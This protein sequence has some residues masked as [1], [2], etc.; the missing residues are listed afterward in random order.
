MPLKR[1]TFSGLA[2]PTL[3]RRFWAKVIRGPAEDDCWSWAGTKSTAGYGQIRAGRAGTPM[4]TAS[5]VSYEIHFGPIPDGEYVC[6]KCDNPE[7]CNP[8]HLFA[9]T[10]SGNMQDAISKG[11]LVTRERH[12]AYL[13]PDRAARG[14]YFK[15]GAN[16]PPEFR[17]SGERCGSAKLRECDVRDIR[18]RSK[19]GTSHQALASEYKVTTDNIRAI[20]KRRSWKHI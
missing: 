12:W 4:L 3:T 16:V 20:V 8:D 7:C 9:A 14:F 19:D 2:S 15:K 1:N 13:D 18:R 6:H 5:R 10:N 11:R 17:M